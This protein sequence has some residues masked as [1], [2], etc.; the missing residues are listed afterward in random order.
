MKVA[1]VCKAGR[2]TVL[3]A[4]VVLVLFA[5]EAGASTP[6]PPVNQNIGIPDGVF[7]DLTMEGCGGCHFDPGSSP[8][9]VKMGYLPDRHHLRVDTPIGSHSAS[10]FPES[11]PDGTHKCTTCHALD[12]REDPSRPAGG[13]FTFALDPAQPEFRNCLRCHTQKPGVA[14]VHH[15]TQAAREARCNSCHGSVINDPNGELWQLKVIPSMS[16][17]PGFGDGDFGPTGHR[18]GGCR[19]CHN[20]G[21]DDASGR[22]VPGP[23]ANMMT[24]HGT[25]LG[26]PGS[27]SGHTC[28]LCHDLTPPQHTLQGC[29][30]CHA[31]TSLHSIQAD[32]DGNG[33]AGTYE[34]QPFYGHIGTSFDCMGCHMGGSSTPA[35]VS[36]AAAGEEA[37]FGPL[38]PEIDRLSSARIVAGSPFTLQL[39]GSG[40]R[41]A[42]GQD[43]VATL[44]RLT[45]ADMDGPALELTPG[46]VSFT[47]MELQLP[48]TLAPGSYRISAVNGTMASVPLNLV[49]TP[50]VSVSSALCSDGTVTVSGSGFGSHLDAQGSG[51]GVIDLDTS[52]SCTIRS[53]TDSRIVADC[54]DRITGSIRV[55]S[56]FGTVVADAPGCRSGGRPRWW[57]IWSWWSSWSWSRR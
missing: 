18:E 15:L 34:E 38:L 14:S 42:T 4:C 56:V 45:P 12:W 20:G 32:S 23:N 22:L 53:W 19:Y 39:S 51:T 37:L 13:Y 5:V 21:V 57:S 36:A 11:S 28:S 55:E 40:F 41:V 3:L 46:N 31:P 52:R 47:S 8:A 17:N 29:V 2:T 33:S 24:H 50:P 35:S 27:G 7:N 25:G 48:A 6:P 1:P 49:V 26:Q 10:P 44:V 43:P 16:P 54:G 30:R 9:P